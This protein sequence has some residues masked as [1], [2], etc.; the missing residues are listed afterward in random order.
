MEWKNVKN[1]EVWNRPFYLKIA[2]ESEPFAPDGGRRK[3]FQAAIGVKMVLEWK[4]SCCIPADWGHGL[5][6]L[7]QK[8]A[9]QHLYE[10]Q[11]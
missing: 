1:K 9:S 7:A 8:I 11:A 10:L 5:D 6:D 4:Y 2:R 3:L